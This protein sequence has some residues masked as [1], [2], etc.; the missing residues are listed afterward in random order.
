MSDSDIEIW[1][2]GFAKNEKLVSYNPLLHNNVLKHYE[3]KEVEYCIRLKKKK[4][5]LESHGYYRGIILPVCL[6][7]ELFGGW[8]LDRVH[9][10]F[11]NLFL[12]DVITEE[13]AGQVHI[14]QKVRS[15]SGISKKKMGEFID[16]VRGWLSEQSINTPDPVKQQNHDN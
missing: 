8:T 4:P 5:T 14:I 6:Q 16:Q 9:S 12:K 11:A 15:T 1:Q 13:V 10:F 7:S 2:H 3:G